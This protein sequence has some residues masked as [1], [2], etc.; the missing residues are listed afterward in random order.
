MHVVYVY[1]CTWTAFFIGHIAWTLP[2]TPSFVK[3]GLC[4]NFHS[5]L[6]MCARDVYVHH[7]V[8]MSKYVFIQQLKNFIF[9]ILNRLYQSR[10]FNWVIFCMQLVQ[11]N[12][13]R[14]RLFEFTSSV[15]ERLPSGGFHS[16]RLMDL[17]GETRF[18]SIY[19]PQ[20]IESK[21]M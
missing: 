5:F 16:G 18:V 9:F 2:I 4:Q 10:S 13:A 21:N 7:I 6:C 3:N 12:S 20:N 14:E 19:F 1:I 17:F 8:S 11:V 15:A